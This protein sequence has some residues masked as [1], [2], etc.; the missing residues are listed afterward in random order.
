[1]AGL[2]VEEKLANGGAEDATDV[3]G[4]HDNCVGGC[5][6]ARRCAGGEGCDGDARGP[7]VGVGSAQVR[8]MGA[9]GKVAKV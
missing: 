6:N 3:G 1:M 7:A 5:N 9:T 8:H 4:H 2:E